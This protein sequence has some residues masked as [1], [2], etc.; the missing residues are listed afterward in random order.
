MRILIP[1]LL[2][3]AVLTAQEPVTPPA[4]VE[5][6]VKD[7]KLTE[8][9]WN[10]SYEA[11]GLERGLATAK[12][13]AIFEG[14]AA[15]SVQIE[16][17]VTE[18]A[19]KRD[20]KKWRAWLKEAFTKG[21]R[22]MQDVEESTE[23]LPTLIFTESKL[24]IFTEHHAYAFYVRGFQCFI[25]HAYVADKTD[26]SGAR[27]K[28][29]L[30]GLKLG[31]GTGATMFEMMIAAGAGLPIS[32]PRVTLEAGV[33]YAYGDQQRQG[34]NLDLATQVLERAR[35]AMKKDTYPAEQQYRLFSAGGYA[36]LA[37][38]KR[39]TKAAIT[40][41]AKAEEFALK[42]P[43]EGRAQAQAGAAYNLACAYSLDGDTDKGFE[44][45]DRSF[46]DVMPVDAGHLTG[47]TDL[48]NLKKDQT[49]WDKFWKERVAGR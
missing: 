16:I 26:K 4:P 12:Q 33:R 21:K 24:D 45:L 27:I 37:K 10:F 40:W 47:D 7:G 49:R 6:V 34:V 48:N 5:A 23:G 44:A 35:K 19:D 22:A 13:G 41:L 31:K 15:G 38:E 20:G 32:D 9:T 18:A 17:R 8:P 14:R 3:T 29:C 46:K 1:L 36:H 28:E 30:T 43:E 42:M 25:V 39:D 11:R 2:L